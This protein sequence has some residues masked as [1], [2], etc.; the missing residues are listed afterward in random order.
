[1]SGGAEPAPGAP[2]MLGLLLELWRALTP[3]LR[4]R[5]GVTVVLMLVAG[6]AELAALVALQSFLAAAMALPGAERLLPAAGLF[7]VA[8]VAVAAARLVTLRVSD[9]L[10]IGFAAHACREIVSRALHQPY[11]AHLERQSVELFAAIESMQRIVN[12][13][14]G[15]LV[16][17]IVSAAIAAA[18]LG[19][20]VAAAPIV[21]GIVLGLILLAYGSFAAS[22]RIRLREG[23]DTTRRIELQRLKILHEAQSG[24]RD[25][26]LAN[27]QGRVI[28]QFFAL[29]ARYRDHQASI[30]FASL[31][32]RYVVEMIAGLIVIALVVWWTQRTEGL[33]MSIP[34]IGALALALQRLMPLLNACYSSWSEFQANS[35]IL[36]AVLRLMRRPLAI[37]RGEMPEPLGLE[38]EIRVEDV[39]WHY[40]RGGPVLRGANL[41]IAKG[42]RVGIFGRSGSGKSTLLDVVLALIEPHK[43]AVLIDGAALDSA[44]RRRAWQG[45]LACVSQHTYLRDA[46]LAAVVAD[47][48]SESTID[49]ARVAKAVAEAG[50]GAFVEGLPQGLDTRVGEGGLLVSGG[51]RQRLAIARALYRNAQVLVLDEATSQLDPASEAELLDT[52]ERLGRAITVLIV[53]HREAALSGCDHV[54][55]LD[56]GV[57]TPVRAP[58]AG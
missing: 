53:A 47:T 33:A 6:A 50:L 39:H 41:V 29:E 55:R 24:Y 10:S 9:R 46:S 20:L 7:A 26:V 52:L 12:L 14:L 48:D 49:R 25:L 51:Q 27:A 3:P 18:L 44:E 19:Y 5:A 42:E 23:S 54:Y 21:S 13:V 56:R 45:Q 37:P 4:R 34:L 11:L 32:P 16:A 43:G 58:A 57:L 38:R 1:M 30:R 31:A 15:P 2:P 22:T 17:A 28:D 40:G 8:V 36:D 35:A